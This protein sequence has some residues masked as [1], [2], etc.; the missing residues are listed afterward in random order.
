MSVADAPPGPSRPRCAAHPEEAASGTCTRCGTFFCAACARLISG[1]AYCATCAERP[2]FQLERFRLELW[3][4][5][6]DWAWLVGIYGLGFAMLAVSMPG[7]WNVLALS[8]GACAAAC[9]AFF[10]GL[11]WARLAL[12]TTPLFVAGV[13]LYLGRPV[14]ATLP[15]T[16][17]LTFLPSYGD[18]RNRL[19][20]RHE[21]PLPR[22]QRLWHRREHN[23]FAREALGFGAA[24]L[25][26]PLLAP[27]AII[28]GA[29]A[30]RRV[31]PDGHKERAIAVGVLGTVTFLSWAWWVAP[32]LPKLLDG[33]E[34]LGLGRLLPP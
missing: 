17:F 16:L 12:I 8:F 34:S 10:L 13:C 6:D 30:L 21:V 29:Q 2:D 33:L 32:M 27:L 1:K 9:G 26:L 5:R 25:I 7:R 23:L 24:S 15:V 14:E 20:F 3:G 4:R 19:F 22:L 28:A 11:R 31:K 18:T